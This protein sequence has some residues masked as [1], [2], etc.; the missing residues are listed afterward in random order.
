MTSSGQQCLIK[1]ILFLRKVLIAD[2]LNYI[3]GFRY[4]IYCLSK[5]SKTTQA[6]VHCD[7]SPEDAL[8]FN[9]ARDAAADRYSREVFD[10]LVMRYEAPVATNRWDAPLFLAMK[11][12]DLD[13]EAV[14][15]AL[16]LRK[17]PPPNQSTQN[18]PLSAANFLHE[19]D[20][21]T[22]EINFAILTAQKTGLACEGDE[23]KV[24]GTET[25]VV[26]VKI[27]NMAELT[28]VKRQFMTYAKSR[29]VVDVGNL[30]TMYVQYM[31][32][33]LAT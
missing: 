8:A 30:A 14:H 12:R 2:G 25:K 32:T 5:A 33:S 22:K 13:L 19:L 9:A 15:D 23:V 31:N 24:P 21:I 11:G 28:R 27:L 4:E 18:Q 10:A 20:R 17:A 6:T 26:L 7:L 29:A 16:F 1:S 3:K